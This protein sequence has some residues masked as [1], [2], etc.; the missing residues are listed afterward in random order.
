MLKKILF[1]LLPLLMPVFV[2]ADRLEEN[3]GDKSIKEF[4]I[5]IK[6]Y[7][8]GI[9]GLAAVMF[10]I[11]GGIQ[12]IASSGNKERMESAKKTITYSVVGLI[13]I[14]LSEVI[15]GI[16]TGGNFLSIFK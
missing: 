9:A 3:T 8:L 7:L 13:L 4:L 6:D 5:R 16:L 10:I 15:L 1:Y 12:Y 2:F 14:V 11:W